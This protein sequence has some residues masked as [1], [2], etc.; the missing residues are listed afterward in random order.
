MAKKIKLRS[1]RL[2]LAVCIYPSSF[3][4]EL[5]VFYKK[6]IEIYISYLFAPVR[7]LLY[8]LFINYSILPSP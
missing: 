7:L 5:L 8:I 2:R 4:E 1:S 6:L 3:V